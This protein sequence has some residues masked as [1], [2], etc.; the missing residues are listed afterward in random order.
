M[1]QAF[2]Y[3]KHALLVRIGRSIIETEMDRFKIF[4]TVYNNTDIQ[5]KLTSENVWPYDPMHSPEVTFDASV[6]MESRNKSIIFIVH[7]RESSAIL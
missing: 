6:K 4:R 7:K 2:H 1:S 5:I 3:K